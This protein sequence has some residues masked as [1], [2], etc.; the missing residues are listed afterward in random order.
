MA[1]SA[2]PRRTGFVGRVA[3]ITGASRGIGAACARAFADQGAQVVLVA[4]DE[5][6][7][8]RIARE[9][10]YGGVVVPADLSQQDAA[11]VTATRILSEVGPVDFLINNAGVVRRTAPDHVAV[12][13]ADLQLMVNLRSA[14]ILTSRLLDSMISKRGAVVNISSVAAF[15]GGPYQAVYS[16]SKGGLNSFGRNIALALAGRGVRVNTIA[17]GFI[18]TEILAPLQDQLGDDAFGELI[19]SSV[20]MG[21]TGTAQEVAAVAR[22]LCSEESSYVTGQTI[23]VDGGMS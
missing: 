21:R 19:R 13:D 9:L 8:E 12:A 17:C 16:A 14:I 2:E 1:K 5:G 15:G 20:P 10:P 7:L 23:R 11:E 22:F 18:D 6:A 4:R 3:V